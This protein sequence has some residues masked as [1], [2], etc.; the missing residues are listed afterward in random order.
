MQ[1]PNDVI[2]DRIVVMNFVY[3]RCTTVCPIDSAIFAQVQARLGERLGKEVTL[4]SLSVDPT[5]DTPRRLKSY[6]KK[7]GARPG[8]NWFTGDK[9]SVDKILTGLG[10]YTPDFDDHPSMVL[11]G[12]GK[13]GEWTRFFGF[14]GPIQILAI[15]DALLAARKQT[16]PAVAQVQ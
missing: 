8:W 11:V 15:V 13:S 14:P 2:G 3:T 16:E 12:D 7:V 9:T 6:A 4:V 10:A 1:F 5:V